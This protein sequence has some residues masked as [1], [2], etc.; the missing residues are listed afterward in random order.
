MVRGQR[1]DGIVR[2]RV[3]L[4]RYLEGRSEGDSLQDR[5]SR[6]RRCIVKMSGMWGGL[7]ILVAMVA[8]FEIETG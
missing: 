8:A 7:V 3:S 5:Q 4:R 1:D 6:G 2:W